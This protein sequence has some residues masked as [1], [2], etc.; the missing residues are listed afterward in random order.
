[1]QWI[2]F[3]FFNS[4]SAVIWAGGLWLIHTLQGEKKT[5]DVI[6]RYSRGTLFECNRACKTEQRIAGRII[7]K[8]NKTVVKMLFYTV[9][10]MAHI[11]FFIFWVSA[12]R[13]HVRENPPEVMSCSN[14]PAWWGTSTAITVDIENQVKLIELLFMEIPTNNLFLRYLSYLCYYVGILGY[15]I[16]V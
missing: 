13:Y 1:M 11:T 4:M 3:Y 16:L 10:N 6:G 7:D 12:L 14:I 8:E 2:H 5:I 9:C 15:S